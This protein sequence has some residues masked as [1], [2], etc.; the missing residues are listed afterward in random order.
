[1][2]KYFI[3]DDSGEEYE[4]QELEAT[5]KPDFAETDVTIE[6]GFSETEIL[7]LKRL[8]PRVDDILTL[9]GESKGEEE[10]EEEAEEIVDVD[11]TETEIEKEK[12]IKTK[13]SRY[14]FGALEPRKRA[15]TDNAQEIEIAE[16][17][18]KRYGGRK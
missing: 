11:E 4:V 5:E 1:M 2:R 10:V 14:S 9:V 18:S 12:E 6:D 7:A 17:W 8:I 3:T 13:D 15:A 16:A